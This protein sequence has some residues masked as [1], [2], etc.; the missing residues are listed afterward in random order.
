MHPCQAPF[1]LDGA[2]LPVP[3]SLSEEA[4]CLP[5]AV[6]PCHLSFVCYGIPRLVLVLILSKANSSNPQDFWS[7]SAVRSRKK[8]QEL[9]PLFSQVAGAE[10]K[11]TGELWKAQPDLGAAGQTLK[12]LN[13]HNMRLQEP[14]VIPGSWGRLSGSAAL[15]HFICFCEGMISSQFALPESIRVWGKTLNLTQSHLGLS[16]VEGCLM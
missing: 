10:I 11:K 14:C 8:V 1:L 6:R 2:A 4:Q 12:T 9:C 3:G 5:K 16:W 13:C 15:L 7:T